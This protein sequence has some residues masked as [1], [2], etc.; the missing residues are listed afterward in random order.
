[1]ILRRALSRP[2]FPHSIVTDNA[3]ASC[4]CWRITAVFFLLFPVPGGAFSSFRGAFQR[5]VSGAAHA[6]RAGGPSRHRRPPAGVRA[7]CCLSRWSALPDERPG[8]AAGGVLGSCLAGGDGMAPSLT[9]ARCGRGPVRGPGPSRSPRPRRRHPPARARGRAAGGLGRR[10]PV[11]GSPPFP[12][13]TGGTCNHCVLVSARY[14][15]DCGG[16]RCLAGTG[17]ALRKSTVRIDVPAPRQAGAAAGPGWPGRD[18]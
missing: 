1:M 13:V 11:I 7:A 4:N 16:P 9:P 2:A 10:C 6:R 18:G 5:G 12:V 8:L 17:A 3:W 14:V 15:T